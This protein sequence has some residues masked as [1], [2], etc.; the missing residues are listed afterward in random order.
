MRVS[1]ASAIPLVAIV[2]A[3]SW[4][5]PCGAGE[6]PSAPILRVET[7]MHGA[8][9]RRLVVDPVHQ[10]LITAGDDKTV[11]VWQLAQGRLERVLRLPIGPGYEGRIY[12]LALSPDGTTIAAGGWTGWDWDGQ[13]SVYLFDTRTGD[14]VRR[15]AGFP[16]VIGSLAYSKDGQRLAVGLHADGGLWVL[17]TS[18]YTPVARDPDYRDKIL[19]A[20]FHR[21]GRLAVTALDG[22]VRLYDRD[23]RLL[24]RVRT[25]PGGKPLT[26]RFSP[27]GNLLALSFNDAASPAVIRTTDL[28]LAFTPD[29]TPAGGLV[30][31]TEVAWS[32]DG[33]TL[34][35][36]GER[37][38]PAR[39]ALFRW[40]EGG[41]GALEELATGARQRIAD[42][43]AMSG[44]GV[45]FAAEDP[46]IG[47]LDAA[48]RQVLARGP[49]LGQ[50]G[51]DDGTLKVSNDGARVQF[52]FSERDARP[53]RFSVLARELRHGGGGDLSGAVITSP[54][55]AITGWRDRPTPVINGEQVRLDD[56]EVGRTYAVSP[57]RLTLVLGTEWALRAYD[58]NASLRWKSAVPG[59]VRGIAVTPR[60]D[61]AVAALS[62]GTMRWYRM[63]DGTEFLALFVDAAGEE[64]IAW[65]PAGYYASS[66]AGDNFVGWHL[67]RGK[68]EAGD[69]YRAV[70]FERV[71]YRPD[72]VD[73]A[74]RSR[75]RPPA[76]PARRAQPKFDVSQLESI[77]PPRVRLEPV[78][79][80]RRGEDGRI[81]GTLRIAARATA[82]PMLEYTVFVNNVPVTPARD[83]AIPSAR[84]AS[85]ATDAAIALDPGE[86]RVRIEI[87]TGTSL[88]FAETH[89]D[90]GGPPGE[91]PPRGNLY[92]LAVGVNE[93][94]QLK[95]ADLKFAARDAQEVAKALGRT[96]ARHF[97]NVYT[98]SLSDLGESK[99]DRSRIVEALEF[100]ADAEADDTVVLFLASH[101]VSDAAGNY[102]FLP[103][104]ARSADVLAVTRGTDADA[105]SLMRWDVIATALRRTAGR[106]VLIVDTCHARS[107]EGRADL[108]SLAKRSAASRFALVL[109]SQA[110]EESQEYPPAG[111]GLFTYALLQGL[112]GA[113]DANA[114]GLITLEEAFRHAVPIVEGLR[115]RSIGEQTPQLVAPDPLGRAVVA[116]TASSGP[117]HGKK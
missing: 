38:A 93:F 59:A 113:A 54:E 46:A 10:R 112:G 51:H 116:R 47:V 60:G 96:G 73:E 52:A 83:R 76:G 31:V 109:A 37:A 104:D 107:V 49:E 9:I 17:R 75:G 61:V 62:D 66:A 32:E 39:A 82:L 103:R 26:V 63:E 71:L 42:L 100:L 5:V 40:R 70:Q 15:V 97:R 58:R 14:L 41:R 20:D 78:G 25:A 29:T 99:P 105:P 2:A 6:P 11:R 91:V 3:L 79:S 45:A 1:A 74:F 64:W 111:H 92:V 27:D 69:F 101:G 22:H 28:A 53:M 102:Y 95:N 24:G 94:P 67:N 90:V 30:A 23:L 85:F 86:N 33:G 106:R 16:D 13:G 110:H 87:S 65:T 89:L 44:G 81:R 8:L 117:R 36:A 77:A 98:R 56:Y 57:D 55:F 68:D 50:F 19:G 35:A 43:Q 48:G 34:Y 4:A 88:A 72:L 108:Q 114:D 18:D 80:M 84:R 115:D 7:D 21:D 12:A